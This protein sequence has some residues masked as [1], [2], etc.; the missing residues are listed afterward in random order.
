MAL[1]CA[2]AALIKGSLRGFAEATRSKIE[3]SS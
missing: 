1:L 2:A 3:A